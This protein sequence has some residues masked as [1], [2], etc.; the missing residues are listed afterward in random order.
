[1]SSVGDASNGVFRHSIF[2]GLFVALVGS[3][4]FKSVN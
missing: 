3:Q 4:A 1:V 2:S